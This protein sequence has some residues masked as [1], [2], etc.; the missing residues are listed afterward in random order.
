[1]E[2]KTYRE[3]GNNARQYQLPGPVTYGQLTLKRGMTSS[4]DL[5]NW[6]D[7]VNR[8]SN[9]GSGAK[10]LVEILSPD[11]SQTDATFR[12]H[13]C[14]PVK[15]KAPSLSATEGGIAIEEL[16]LAYE[17]LKLEEATPTS[18]TTEKPQ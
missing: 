3:G 17:H 7:Q 8:A 13:H 4:F 15:M 11:G 14:V 16:Q 5:W 6:F 1:M 2:P 12:L 10:A 9:Y 18:Q